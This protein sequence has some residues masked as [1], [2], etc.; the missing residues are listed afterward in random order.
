MNHKNTEVLNNF[1]SAVEGKTIKFRQYDFLDGLNCF[2][3][4]TNPLG[5]F[6]PEKCQG[7]EKKL[8]FICNMNCSISKNLAIELFK[9]VKFNSDYN[10]LGFYWWVDDNSLHIRDFIKKYLGV[11]ISSKEEMEKFKD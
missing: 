8:Q 9:A 2:V 4:D 6:P 3:M 11:E 7:R 10:K 5:S 1:I